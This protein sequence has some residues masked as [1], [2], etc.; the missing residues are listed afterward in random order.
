[1]PRFPKPLLAGDP[2]VGTAL[3]TGVSRL[4]IA[5]LEVV[6]SHVRSQG[7]HVIEGERLHGQ[8]KDASAPPTQRAHELMRFLTDPAVSAIIPPW[9]GERAIELLRPIDFEALRSASPKWLLGYSDLSAPCSY[10]SRS[11][12]AGRLHPGTVGRLP[13]GR[14]HS[15]VTCPQ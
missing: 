11:S 6:L 2:I 3:S 8:H 1:M 4:A 7:Y 13:V 5:R 9:G 10:R 15:P 14:S 12:P